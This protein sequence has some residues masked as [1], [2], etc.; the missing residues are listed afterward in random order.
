LHHT[1]ALAERLVRLPLWPG[2]EDQQQQ[3]IDA[4]VW[5]LA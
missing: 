5:A 3:V 4:V 2:L 1:E